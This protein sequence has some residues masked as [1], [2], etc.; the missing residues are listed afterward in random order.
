MQRLVEE[1]EAKKEVGRA[2]MVGV[3]ETWRIRALASQRIAD[4]D[5]DE[6][7]LGWIWS[8]LAGMD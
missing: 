2:T 6:E 1:E 7:V 5:V 4:D 3:F 8:Q